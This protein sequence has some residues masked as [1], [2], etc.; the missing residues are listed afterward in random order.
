MDR[1]GESGSEDEISHPQKRRRGADIMKRIDKL[2][3]HGKTLSWNGIT[4]ANHLEITY[5]YFIISSATI[6]VQEYLF[7]LQIGKWF[8]KISKD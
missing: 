7:P 2:T 3:K 8:L 1:E 5:L 6:L 4:G